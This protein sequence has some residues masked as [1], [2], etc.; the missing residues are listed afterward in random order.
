MKRVCLRL[1]E[2]IERLLNSRISDAT[3]TFAG[4][5]SVSDEKN[6]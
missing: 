4:F 3:V 6:R 5:A 1:N 2:T